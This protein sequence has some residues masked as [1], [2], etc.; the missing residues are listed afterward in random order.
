[1]H[2]FALQLFEA[3]IERH[4]NNIIISLTASLRCLDHLFEKC[5]FC[6]IHSCSS[7]FIISLHEI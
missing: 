2:L 6:F 3:C 7:L 4:V 5:I 1:M